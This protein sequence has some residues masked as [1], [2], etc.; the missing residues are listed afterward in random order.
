M[1]KRATGAS[2]PAVSDKIVKA[3]HV[4]LPTLEEQK[5]IAKILDK[6]DSIRA[7]RRQ[8][9]DHLD[10]L[11]QSIFHDMFETCAGDSLVPLADMADIV[12]GVTK[13]RRT[14]EPTQDVPY[15]A[16]VNVQ[17]GHLKLSEVKHIEATSSEI[18]RYSLREGDLILTEGGDPDKL[19]RGAMWRG[20]IPVC[21]HQNHIFRVRL[22]DDSSVLPEYMEAYLS[23][24]SAKDYFLK[25]AKQTTGIASINMRQLKSL[26]VKV[27]SIDSQRKFVSLIASIVSHKLLV[28]EQLRSFDLL[29]TSL[30]SRAFKGE[31]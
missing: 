3:S 7:K 16:V 4:P 11:S 9:L 14:S 27:P 12:S 23:S 18:Q 13:G 28:E 31:L 15:L 17:A 19:G 25:S 8:V 10:A 5:R 29:F 24:R 20:E 22:N 1:V 26:P 30:Q 2:Y 6:A 21:I